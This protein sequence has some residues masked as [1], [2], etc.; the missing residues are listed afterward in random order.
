[1]EEPEGVITEEGILLG[2]PGE[3][4]GEL[5][6]DGVEIKLEEADDGLLDIAELPGLEEIGPG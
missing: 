1:M 5:G 4:G 6:N 2:D 3:D